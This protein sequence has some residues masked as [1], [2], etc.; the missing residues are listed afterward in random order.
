VSGPLEVLLGVGIFTGVVLALVGVILLARTVL[1]A[2]GEVVVLVNGERRL[3]GRAGE[4]LTDV[5]AGGG[6]VLPAACG[7]RGTCG[8]CRIA[9]AGAAS[10]PT[11]T[12]AA[13]LSLRELS[14]GVR[15]ACQVRLD[16]DLEV[17]VAEELLGVHELECTVRSNDNVATFIKELVLELPPDEPFELRAG[18]FVQL[19]CPPYA[20]AFSD[21]DVAERYREDWDRLD[22][23]RLRAEA[24]EPTTRAYSLANRPDE[25]D[26]LVLDVRI[27][28]PP[29]HATEAPPGVVSS[30]IFTL[31]PGDR[32]AVSGPYG[33]F[34]AS[35]GERE[36]VFVG[37]GAGM[38]P[39]RAHVFDQLER[40][41]TKR[42][43]SFW[44]GARSARE[45]FYAEEFDRL[46]AEHDN[47]EWT[48]AL[49]EPRPADRW[50]GPV[51]FI[52]EVL[53]ERSLSHHTA[54][55]DCEYYLC[56][57]P[58]MIRATRRMLDE[59]GVRPE[60]VHYDDFGGAG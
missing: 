14:G 25:T 58:M 19:T 15:L 39:M 46:Q 35:E 33:H 13:L 4:K 34:F 41:D 53:L 57:P 16:G 3:V 23:W 9:L 36:M 18:S 60:D 55:S 59:L 52:H 24:R 2:A 45:V 8:M 31:R 11:P 30:W 29:P 5:L 50:D 20:A 54:P 49:S 47:F 1:G 7:G 37:G 40:L 10:A 56:G 6:I 27:A 26:V 42:K 17:H 22:L 43:L 38:A 44:Y 21:F 12:D 48:V 28:T 32:V 51:G